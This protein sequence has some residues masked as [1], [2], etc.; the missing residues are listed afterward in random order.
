MKLVEKEA[1]H[2]PGQNDEGHTHT[3]KK[4]TITSVAVVY[5]GAKLMPAGNREH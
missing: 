1:V 4:N 5:N 3:K 2:S